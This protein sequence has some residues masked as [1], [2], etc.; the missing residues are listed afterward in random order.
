MER[1]APSALT[2]NWKSSPTN[3]PRGR[4]TIARMELVT[5]KQVRPLRSHP[6]TAHLGGAGG[7]DCH[8]RRGP[9]M[10]DQLSAS[11]GTDILHGPCELDF[12]KP[13][14][15][16][17]SEIPIGVGLY[18]CGTHLEGDEFVHQ[19]RYLDSCSGRRRTNA[20]SPRGWWPWTSSWLA[21]GENHDGGRSA[22]AIGT[23]YLWF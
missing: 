22:E 5:E 17:E 3:S 11:Q 7:Q 23:G 20:A 18:I 21:D 1:H 10:A 15:H 16:M 8:S 9:I 12:S 13:G 4:S 19:F 2:R 14:G 6:N